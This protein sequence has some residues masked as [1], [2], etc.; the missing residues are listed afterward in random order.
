[1]SLRDEFKE[2]VRAFIRPYCVDRGRPYCPHLE[3]LICKRCEDEVEALLSLEHEG[4]RLLIGKVGAELP[5]EW[6]KGHLCGSCTGTRRSGSFLSPDCKGD[7]PICQR[8]TDF[9]SGAKEGWV[10]EVPSAGQV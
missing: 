8:V 1:M 6:A 3:G 2:K 10:K 5:R 9:I 4:H 7:A